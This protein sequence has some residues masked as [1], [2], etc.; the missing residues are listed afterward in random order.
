MW[1]VKNKNSDDVTMTEGDF[2][3][4]LPYSIEGLPVSPLDDLRF[5]VKT[6]K[7]GEAVL[8]KIFHADDEN[9][10]DLVFTEAESALLVP[11][12]YIYVLDWYSEGE[13]MGNLINGAKLKV[14][15]K[16]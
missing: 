12:N 15:D 4:T 9:T 3:L 10:V 1:K 13:F 11:G 5:T 16:A 6:E 8:E 14:E 7:N 2:G